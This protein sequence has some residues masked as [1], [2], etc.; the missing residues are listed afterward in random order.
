MP[1]GLL[2]QRPSPGT[3]MIPETPSRISFGYK[4]R[5][6]TRIN[7][8]ETTPSTPFAR[9]RPRV[10]NCAVTS[11]PIGVTRLTRLKVEGL[12]G[13]FTGMQ[14]PVKF[15][16]EMWPGAILPNKFHS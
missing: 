1:D 7:S 11:P 15:R 9:C 3:G 4:K 12:P 10:L 8:S 14:L 5:P 13:K 6:S 2:S 16:A